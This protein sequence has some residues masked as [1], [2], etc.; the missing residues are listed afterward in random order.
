MATKPIDCTPVLNALSKFSESCRTDAAAAAQLGIAK[1]TFSK[2]FK[3][4][5]L[6]TGTLQALAAF[7][8]DPAV[9]KA[10]RQ[11]LAGMGIRLATFDFG[12]IASQLMC[13][14]PSAYILSPALHDNAPVQN[15]EFAAAED[16][17]AALADTHYYETF[18][19][20]AV[21]GFATVPEHPLLKIGTADYEH[22]IFPQKD[23]AEVY[24]D[25]KG[26]IDWDR[27]SQH[28]REPHS[29]RSEAAHAIWECAVHEPGHRLFERIIEKTACRL[30]DRDAGTPTLSDQACVEMAAFAAVD[31]Y[32]LES[33]VI[34]TANTIRQAVN[35]ERSLE[36]S[37]LY[38]IATRLFEM[39]YPMRTQTVGRVVS[40]KERLSENT[41]AVSK[42]DGIC[43]FAYQALYSNRGAYFFQAGF[44]T[45]QVNKHGSVVDYDSG[46]LVRS[47]VGKK[48]H[49]PKR[50]IVRADKRPSG[51]RRAEPTHCS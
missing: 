17:I 26:E 16:L 43:A 13:A 7:E 49:A 5:T 9:A 30:K 6:R 24:R 32:K 27:I 41:E 8:G 34:E 35:A 51:K 29:R 11:A 18:A 4:R 20:A 46:R 37:P 38:T 28:I 19:E 10:A 3:K 1:G 23:L 40:L 25:A 21:D 22:G 45:A 2:W 15:L 12:H 42:I 48:R 50:A 36:K 31:A 39:R 44:A 14:G 47:V 33:T